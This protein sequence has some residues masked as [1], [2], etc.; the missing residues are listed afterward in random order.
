M[1]ILAFVLLTIGL[2]QSAGCVPIV[3]IGTAVTGISLIHDRRT[4]GTIV[5]DQSIE[6]RALHEVS[7]QDFYHDSNISFVSYNNNLL[8]VGQVPTR[9]AKL[10]S[11]Q[12]V[13]NIAKVRTVYNEL[14]VGPTTALTTRTNDTLITGKVKARLLANK[15]IDPTKIKVVTEN[16]TVYLMGI[17]SREEAHIATEETKQVS[18][19]YRITRLFEYK[20][21]A[22]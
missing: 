10:K 19:V 4:A 15:D 20:K 5:E 13:Q 11:Q 6:F 22:G 7:K 9:E 14:A 3:A 18:G 8:L 16:A 12:L 2:L 17:V 1:R 21:V